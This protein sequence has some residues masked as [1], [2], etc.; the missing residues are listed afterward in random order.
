MRKKLYIEYD[1]VTKTYAGYTPAY[2]VIFDGKKE[3]E[4][5][6]YIKEYKFYTKRYNKAAEVIE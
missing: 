1:P 3:E 2:V 6:E 4:L 5:R